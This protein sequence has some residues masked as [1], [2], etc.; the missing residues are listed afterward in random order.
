MVTHIVG[1][2]NSK[3]TAKTVIAKTL[4]LD[5]QDLQFIVW[6]SGGT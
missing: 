3:A 1:L 5:L 2:I 4:N 6:L